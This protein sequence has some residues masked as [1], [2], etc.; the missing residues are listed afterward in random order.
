LN[1]S[2]HL[3]SF[4]KVRLPSSEYPRSEGLSTLRVFV[5]CVYIFYSVASNSQ[6]SPS[7]RGRGGGGESCSFILVRGGFW[8]GEDKHSLII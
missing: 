4:S 6:F 5:N 1:S 2:V 7:T 3:F 8:G